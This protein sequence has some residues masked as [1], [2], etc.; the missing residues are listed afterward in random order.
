M[1]TNLC[2]GRRAHCRNKHNKNTTAKRKTAKK[3][4][5]LTRKAILNATTEKTLML[6]GG[7]DISKEDFIELGKEVLQSKSKIE[8]GA[9]SKFEKKMFLEEVYQW[10]KM[11]SQFDDDNEITILYNE[12]YQ[13][14]YKHML[15]LLKY[16]LLEMLE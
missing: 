6:Q 11:R 5:G 7:A 14:I 15:P 10:F 8:S 12:L 16:G 2:K 3:V 4:N 1:Q 13:P 9:A